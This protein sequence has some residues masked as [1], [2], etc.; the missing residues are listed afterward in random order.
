MLAVVAALIWYGLYVDVLLWHWY[1]VPLGVRE[2][3]IV[4]IFG[5]QL[6]VMYVFNASRVMRRMLT[7][8]PKKEEKNGVTWADIREVLR[9]FF[10]VLVFS[11]SVHL[12]GWLFSGAFRSPGF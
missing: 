1:L 2:V 9:I 8:K 3:G 5:V 7:V 4:Q 11:A 10:K 6:A 12:V